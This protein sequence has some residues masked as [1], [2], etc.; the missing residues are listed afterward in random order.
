MPGQ[1]SGS[2]TRTKTDSGPCRS[3]RAACSRLRSTCAKALLALISTSGIATS[4]DAITAPCQW[5]I[6]E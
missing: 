1:A 3:V 4:A 6:T 2:V 5:K